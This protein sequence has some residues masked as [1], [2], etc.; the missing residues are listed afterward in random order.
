MSPYDTRRI[1]RIGAKVA[2]KKIGEYLG[3]AQRARA[4]AF[5]T[6]HQQPYSRFTAAPKFGEVTDRAVRQRIAAQ[7]GRPTPSRS[8][9]YF[10]PRV[11]ITRTV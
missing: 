10:D 6:A 11:R 5:Q 4:Q 1:S 8:L 2:Y 9:Q 7:L 3:P